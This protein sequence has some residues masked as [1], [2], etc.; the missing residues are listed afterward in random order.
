MRSSHGSKSAHTAHRAVHHRPE[1][2]PLNRGIRQPPVRPIE[3]ISIVHH[4]SDES[5]TRRAGPCRVLRRAR[6][7]ARKNIA[8]RESALLI[9]LS[10]ASAPGN[11][12]R[13]STL[14]SNVSGRKSY[15]AMR[16]GSPGKREPK[17]QPGAGIRRSRPS[18]MWASGVCARN[19]SEM[20][21]MATGGIESPRYRRNAAEIHSFTRMRRCCG[22][23]LELDHV[24]V[25]VGGF[26]K[27]R[28]RSAAHL[29]HQTAGINRHSW[30]N[31]IRLY[32]ATKKNQPR[33]RA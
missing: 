21:T 12:V 7:L 24:E 22:L 31:L 6:T 30:S 18:W 4:L 26:E 27:V 1:I 33:A 23:L 15:T 3:Y 28:L 25:A 19:S 2:Q 20:R 14:S 17:C 29:A 32:D 13:F 5:Q 8:W 9:H 16:A 10:N 11:S